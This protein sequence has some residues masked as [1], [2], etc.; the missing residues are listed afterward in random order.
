MVYNSPKSKKTD[1]GE[2][3]PRFLSSCPKDPTTVGLF[4]P[5]LENKEL[6]QHY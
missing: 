4:Y 5:P 6:K 3:S 2:F 1:Y